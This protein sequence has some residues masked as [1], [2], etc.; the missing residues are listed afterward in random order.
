MFSDPET[1]VWL[2]AFG[3]GV[4]VAVLAL[5]RMPVHTERLG[6]GSSPRERRVDDPD[7]PWAGRQTFGSWTKG[8]AAQ[9]RLAPLLYLPL[10]SAVAGGSAMLYWSTQLPSDVALALSLLCALLASGT[11]LALVWFGYAAFFR[12]PWIQFVAAAIAVIAG[13]LRLFRKIH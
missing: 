5:W 13:L 4:V 12:S 8:T 11:V 10:T 9:A 3:L 2:Y 1:Q 6:E 7:S